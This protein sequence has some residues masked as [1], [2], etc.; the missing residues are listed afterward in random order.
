MKNRKDL[1]SEF[2][3]IVD[4]FPIGKYVKTVVR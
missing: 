3:S 2:T 1:Q 4:A